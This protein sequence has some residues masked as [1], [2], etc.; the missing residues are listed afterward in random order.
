VRLGA[1]VTEVA[2][3][4]AVSHVRIKAVDS[5]AESDLA[6]AGFFACVGLVPNT[7]LLRG[8]VPL[9]ATGRVAVD[10]ALRTPAAGI[11]AAGN[12]RQGSPHR[13]AGAMGDGATAALSIHRY[14]TTGEW[15]DPV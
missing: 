14:L 11:C 13:A 2:G 7:G 6:T 15:R 9:D 8:L 12:V 5:G 4:A 3:D 10:A 1:T